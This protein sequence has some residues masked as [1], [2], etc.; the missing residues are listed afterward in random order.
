MSFESSVEPA[1]ESA[2]NRLPVDDGRAVAP[3]A[4]RPALNVL[5]GLLLFGLLAG[6]VYIVYQPQLPAA[7]GG[8]VPLQAA[9]AAR[10]SRRRHGQL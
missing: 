7:L 2:D 6:G 9:H 5:L 8:P 3:A 10:E 4:H 1:V